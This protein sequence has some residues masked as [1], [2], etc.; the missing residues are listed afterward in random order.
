[1]SGGK[2]KTARKR[3]RYFFVKVDGDLHLHQ[4][5]HINRSQDL[6]LAWDYVDSKRKQYV[7]SD[8]KRT[9]QNAF[10]LKEVSEILGVHKMTVDSYVREER[11]PTPQRKY[12]L[13]TRKPGKYFMSEDDVL[14]LHLAMSET[15][16]GRPRNDG[17]VTNN[18]LPTRAQVRTLVRQ[19]DVLYTKDEDGQF[20]P[21]WKEQVW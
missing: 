11:I 13:S 21:I 10:S 2:G 9:M 5:L 14:D 18:G 4:V 8:V 16:R 1:M 6:V 15:H 19:G 20:V 17:L 7:W 3:I 12:D